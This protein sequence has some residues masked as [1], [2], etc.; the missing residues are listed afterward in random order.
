MCVLVRHDVQGVDAIDPVDAQMSAATDPVDAQMSAGSG[1]S[2]LIIS[3]RMSMPMF[4]FLRYRYSS[5]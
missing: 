1:D 4:D 5:C 3:L 2:S